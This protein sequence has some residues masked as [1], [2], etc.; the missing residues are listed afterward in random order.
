MIIFIYLF[1]IAFI[2]GL[3]QLSK[4]IIVQTLKLNETIVVIKDFFNITYVQNKGAGFSI[5]Q[6]QMT[7]FYIIT[8]IALILLSYLLYKSKD[9]I[10]II[11]YLFMIGGAIG[12]FIDRLL[13]GY[14]VDFLDFYIF[15]Y[16]YP[17]FNIADSFL[18][19]GVILLIISVLKEKKDGKA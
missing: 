18:T 5:L 6:G 19:I 17:V 14:V 11:A 15:N 13:L 9:K 10:S 16:N 3:D 2:V 4:S 1:V 7:F 8:I 12:N